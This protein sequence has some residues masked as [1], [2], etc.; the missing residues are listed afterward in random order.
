MEMPDNLYFQTACEGPWDMA[1]S[2]QIEHVSN[3]S[4]PD[5]GLVVID[6]LQK[7]R[8]RPIRP[9]ETSTPAT[10]GT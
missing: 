2:E 5:T 1:S 3:P 4:R 7:V 6:T 8:H 9:P 10:T